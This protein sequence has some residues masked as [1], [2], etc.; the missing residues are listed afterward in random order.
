[1]RTYKKILWTLCAFLQLFE[2]FAANGQ[3]ARARR[4]ALDGLSLPIDEEFR[5]IPLYRLAQH[6][7][8]IR[9]EVLKNG[10][11]MLSVYLDLLKHWEFYALG[12]D[13]LANIVRTTWLLLSKLV[14]GESHDNEPLG[15]E[16]L[17]QSDELFVVFG[18]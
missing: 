12:V 6:A 9:L 17:V 16:L 10:M 1:M 3:G 7:A 15:G 18:C 2:D 13:K 14:A 4:V 5:K 8:Q 11:R